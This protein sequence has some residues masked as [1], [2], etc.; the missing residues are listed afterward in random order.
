MIKEEKKAAANNK[1][2]KKI[3][4][5]G[6]D[7]L[8][9]KTIAEAMLDKKARNVVSMDLKSIGTSICDY[10]L[11]CNADATTN[12]L[13]IAENVEERMLSDFNT[14]VI[15][16]QGRENAFWVI[17]DYGNIVVHIFQTEYRAFYR[18]EDLWADAKKT[19][20]ND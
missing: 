5:I 7:E 19:E 12:V 15:R 2:S 3:K 11:I 8:E 13:A 14:K 18:L 6:Q 9:V 20:Y 16:A 10:F 1:R 4:I 17:L